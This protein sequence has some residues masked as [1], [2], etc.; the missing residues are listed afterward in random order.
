MLLQQ[1]EIS[2]RKT[3]RRRSAVVE[4]ATLTNAA[5]ALLFALMLLGERCVGEPK[6]TRRRH[7]VDVDDNDNEQL[8]SAERELDGVD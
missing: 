4:S 1:F 6:R 7:R 5:I 3:K 2:Q 8:A